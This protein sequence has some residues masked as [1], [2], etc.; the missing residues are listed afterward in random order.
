MP[1]NFYTFVDMYTRVLDTTA[2]I[3]TKGADHARGQGVS[4][5]QMLEWRLVDDMNPLSFQL[6]TVC[7]FPRQWL[8]RAVGNEL[9]ADI[10]ACTSVADYQRE[11][12]ATKAYVQ[13]LTPAQFEGREEVPMEITLG[14]GM[15]MTATA[16]QWVKV[17][18]TTNIYFHM[19]I[20]YA[21]LRSRGVPIGKLDLFSTGI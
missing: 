17:F 5:A 7:N 20:A 4:E 9:P 21:I 11:I 18:A 14:G 16:S 15:K 6:N 12:A 1:I 3:L 8:A 19:S 13:A 10:P 2:H